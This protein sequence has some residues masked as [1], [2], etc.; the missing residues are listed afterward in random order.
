MKR[1]NLPK[2][3]I[4][5]AVVI[6]SFIEMNPPVG[7]DLA[8]YFQEKAVPSRKDAAYT[9]IVVS[10]LKLQKEQPLK[11]YANLVEAVGTNDITKYFPQAEFNEVTNERNPSRA[12]LDRLQKEAAGKI[13]LGL[14]LQGGTAFVVA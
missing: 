6:W 3:I 4:V 12:V 11:A 8:L 13:K 10:L 2:L 5:I 7:R 14:D 1:N 9:N